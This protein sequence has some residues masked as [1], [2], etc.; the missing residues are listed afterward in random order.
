MSFHIGQQV[1]CVSDQFSSDRRWRRTV[2]IFPLLRAIY[3]I[4]EIHVE[5]PLMGLCFHEIVNPCTWFSAGYGEP[6]FN[7]LNFR[8]VKQTNIE[9][10]ERLLA[11]ADQKTRTPGKL[12][13]A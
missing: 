5:G 4:R 12:V 10:F 11:P 9:V 7:S 6:A 2:R 3:T 13:D 1:V 8:P